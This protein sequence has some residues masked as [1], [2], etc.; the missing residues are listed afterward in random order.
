MLGS[1]LKGAGSRKASGSAT[2]GTSAG[3]PAPD[4]GDGSAALA[5]AS[6]IAVSVDAP[7]RKKL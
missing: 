5:A 4:S 3:D 1:C 6:S 7:V 2:C